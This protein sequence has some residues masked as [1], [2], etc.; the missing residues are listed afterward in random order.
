MSIFQDENGF[1][2]IW[3]LP[4]FLSL[5][6][7]IHSLFP[8][9]DGILQ[10][11]SLAHDCRNTSLEMQRQLAQGAESLIALNPKA[12]ALRKKRKKTK[13]L[14]QAAKA[15]PKAY[16]AAKAMDLAV[17]MQQVQLR[18]KQQKI[19]QDA[20]RKAGLAF[21]M[22]AAVR[23]YIPFAFVAL[24][25]QSLSPSY[26]PELFFEEKQKIRIEYRWG[27]RKE[28]CGASLRKVGRKWK[29][30]LKVDRS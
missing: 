10:S 22:K 21:Q 27:K 2:L 13:A 11:Q 20:K 5:A 1:L 25:P 30:I 19:I 29:S 9:L 16:A 24:P 12:K 28:F 8:I 15:N 4:L 18:I 14:L 7:L 6:L 17:Q 26:Q 23:P 3:T